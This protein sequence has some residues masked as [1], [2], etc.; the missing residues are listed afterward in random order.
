MS[1]MTVTTKIT[2]QY[3]ERK[4]KSD[5]A[6]MYLDLLDG[7]Q[8]AREDE[9]KACWEDCIQVIRNAIKDSPNSFELKS[10]YEGIFLQGW[11]L[12]G[13]G[14]GKPQHEQTTSAVAEWKAT[15]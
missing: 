5:L 4:T 2:R 11:K 1:V 3:L 10:L 8:D 6:Q 12:M 15:R 13:T 7:E 9:R 14:D